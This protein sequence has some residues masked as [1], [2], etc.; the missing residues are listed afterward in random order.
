MVLPQF[1]YLAPKTIGEAC[2][3]LLELGSPAKVMAGATDLIPPMKDKAILPEYLIDLKKIPDLDYL[4]Y[5]EKEGLKIGALTTLRTIETSPLVKEKNPAVA[6]AAKV[7]ASTQIRAK[8]T[9]AGNIC[10]ASPSCDTAPNLLAQGAKILV[11]GPNKDRI[12]QAEDFFLGVKKTSLEPGEIVTGIVIPPLAENER[13]AYIKHAVRKAMDLAIIGVAVK[14][15]VEDGI[16]TDAHIA[17]GAVAATPIRAPKAE[18]ALIGKALTDEVIVKASE[19]A[20][21]SCHPISD[22][23]AS[24][25]YRK[26]MIRVFTKRAVRQAMECL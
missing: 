13:A 2:N 11:Q 6:H 1:E 26:D 14:I 24:A 12:I 20:M 15:K 10:N 7:V 4:E 21:D 8:G 18:E 23:R 3:L 16:C 19:E 22:I 5:D 9:M 25:E 17:L